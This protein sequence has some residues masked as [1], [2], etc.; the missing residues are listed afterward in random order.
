MLS[1]SPRLAWLFVDMNSFFASVEQ[2]L[3]PELRGIPV[4]V[5]P[6]ESEGTCVI[7]ASREAKARGVKT[8]TGVPEARSMCPRIR[9]VKARPALYVRVH[10]AIGRSI[11][12]CAPVHKVYSIDEWAIRL[13]GKE[14]EP[15]HALDLGRRVRR[16]ILHDFSPWLT[17]SV[18]IA[19]TR[20]LAKIASDL[21]KPDGL[22]VLTS[23]DLPGRLEGL[24]LNDL[25]GI[26]SAMLRRLHA[27]GV[28]TVRQLWDLSPRES[29][30]IWGSVLGESWWHGFH[31]NDLPEAPTRR[32][33]IN[34][35]NMLP[36]GHRDD[37][38]AHAVL[39]RLLC[40]GARRLRLYDLAAHRLHVRVR[41]Y[42]ELEWEAGAPL[43]ATQD[44][45]T[46]VRRFESL[47]GARPWARGHAS[48]WRPFAQ[49]AVTLSGLRPLNEVTPLLFED[50]RPLAPL[51][52]ALDRIN[53]RW[54]R[55]TVYL[56]SVHNCRHEM[57]D[58]IAFGR[59]PEGAS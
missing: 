20:L 10:Q 16:E 12:R 36:P 52:R 19:P 45:L 58:K 24:E 38:G 55:D 22:T 33:S 32:R 29:R 4:G 34:H 6:V 37:D 53:L 2:H 15:E 11:D 21:K 28:R 17:C 49:V 1:D 13:M 8:G 43:E 42:S 39:V 27:A 57:E 18:G 14:R 47:W 25:P 40:N 3:R 31:G 56:G 35:A 26:A 44:T 46:I 23:G 51:S 48:R 9:F 5:V 59:I 7:A 54:G 41:S 50:P 30:R